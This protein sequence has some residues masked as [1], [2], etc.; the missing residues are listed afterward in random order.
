MAVA[1]VTGCSTGLGAAIAARLAGEGYDLVITA[2][3]TSRLGW[4]RE[5]ESFVGRNVL[6]QALT[7]SDP[8]SIA[9]AVEAAFEHF[10][11]ID[12][13]VNNAGSTIRVAALDVSEEQWDDILDGNLKGTFFLTQAVVR[14]V[15]AEKIP[16]RIVNLSSTYG[17][18]GFPN[19]LLYGVSKAG[20]IQMTKMLAAEW[21]PLGITVNAVAPGTIN[22]ESRIEYASDPAVRDLLLQRI[23]VG[24]F[25]EP[26]EVAA[27]VSYLVGPDA[28]F[29][30]GH[31]LVLDGGTTVV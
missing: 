25:G 17:I 6:V 11:Q 8:T 16:F 12:A 23:P 24:R 31:V 28:G 5:H 2:R 21:A 14:R 19:R 9:D 18:V 29:V 7:L 27:A 3:D 15:A 26:S 10:G 22:T 30:T 4:V 13:L 1:F 20:L